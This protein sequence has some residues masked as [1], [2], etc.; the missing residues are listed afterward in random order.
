MYHDTT[1]HHTGLSAVLIA[2][3]AAV[4]VLA[5]TLVAV[6]GTAPGP[7]RP[8]DTAPV[9]LPEVVVTAPRIGG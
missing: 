8:H 7:Y 9:L 2:A 4:Q 5:F 3:I 1:R 6:P